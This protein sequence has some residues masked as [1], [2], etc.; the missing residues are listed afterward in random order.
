MGA[1]RAFEDVEG[2]ARVATL[3]EVRAQRDNL[4]I[5]LYVPPV[6]GNGGEAG[7]KPLNAVIAGWERSSR[8]LR[9]ATADLL[10][11]LEALEHG[12]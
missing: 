12:D 10:T 7:E 6:S 5:P 1:Y 11:V 2:L 4:S 3:D 8:A 9:A